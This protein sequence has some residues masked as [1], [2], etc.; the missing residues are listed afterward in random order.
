[1]ILIEVCQGPDC[2]GLGGGAA[3]LEIEELI[4]EEQEGKISSLCVIEGGCRN[5][6]T[7][8][9]N[10]YAK[11]KKYGTIESFNHVNDTTKCE[12]VVQFAATVAT[13]IG[14]GD[15]QTTIRRI[16]ESPIPTTQSL[17]QSFMTKR[18]ARMRWEALREISRTLA[19]CNK[20][21]KKQSN[22]LGDSEKLQKTLNLLKESMLEALS[23]FASAELSAAKIKIEMDRAERRNIHMSKNLCSRLEA[24]FEENFPDDSSNGGSDKSAK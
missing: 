11:H 10:V 4:Q 7:V 21:S 15:S 24:C 19:K 2:T 12:K 17:H 20:K 23:S 9:P 18:A 13:K 1:M 6:C 3:L 16:A 5:F 22:I 14:K 8:G